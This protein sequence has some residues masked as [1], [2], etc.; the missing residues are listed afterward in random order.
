MN[1]EKV[2]ELS[3]EI[4][5]AGEQV[6]NQV[7]ADK[8]TEARQLSDDSEVSSIFDLSN[9]YSEEAVKNNEKIFSLIS[10][11]YSF[12]DSDD[13]EIVDSFIK[14]YSRLKIEYLAK[15]RLPRQVYRIVGDISVLQINFKQKVIKKFNLKQSQLSEPSIFT[16]LRC[17]KNKETTIDIL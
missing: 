10:N 2:L 4:V 12:I 14:N 11:N 3:R 8:K 17:K 13:I 6:Y 1:S 16:C 5:D 15:K 9:E 7:P